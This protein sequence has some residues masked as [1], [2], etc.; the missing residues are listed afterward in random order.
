M[1]TRRVRAGLRTVEVH[2]PDKVLFPDDGLTKEDLVEYYR[3][4]APF[5]L[6]QLRGRP[7]MLERHP[8]GI[9]GP[10]FMQKQ[11]PDSY[12]DWVRRVEVAKADGP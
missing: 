6:P 7:L 1:G 3:R 2:R 12:P 10:R 5:M 11:T 4:I 9:G 8:D